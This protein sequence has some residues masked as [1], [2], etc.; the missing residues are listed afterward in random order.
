MLPLIGET[1]RHISDCRH[2]IDEQRRR[3]IEQQKR[4]DDTT[5]STNLLATLIHFHA[6]AELRR[7]T[8]LRLSA[9]QRIGA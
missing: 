9:L 5:A 7:E 6:L 3:I 4:G 1:D 8:L 2:R